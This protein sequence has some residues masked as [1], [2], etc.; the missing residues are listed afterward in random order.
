[1]TT[2]GLVGLSTRLAKAVRLTTA[3]EDESRVQLRRSTRI[4]ARLPQFPGDEHDDE[5]N[6]NANADRQMTLAQ[7]IEND[8]T[9]GNRQIGT[10]IVASTVSFSKSEGALERES[11]RTADTTNNTGSI[12]EQASFSEHRV[13]TSSNNSNVLIARLYLDSPVLP[14]DLSGHFFWRSRLLLKY[15]WIKRYI[16]LGSLVIILIC[17]ADVMGLWR[18]FVYGRTVSVDGRTKSSY[19]TKQ[20][21]LVKQMQSL[22]PSPLLAVDPRT[23]QLY[24]AYCKHLGVP[25]I[26]D[27]IGTFVALLAMT[28]LILHE[29]YWPIARLLLTTSPGPWLIA[30]IFEEKIDF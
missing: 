2:A 9:T 28:R 3:E 12:N 27:V 24:P 1:M 4:V 13:T 5:V 15:R 11:A 23:G 21:E 25:H 8:N 17:M 19:T 29:L 30:G 7:N 14:M 18:D 22:S 26:A 20:S 10:S 16:M 6:N